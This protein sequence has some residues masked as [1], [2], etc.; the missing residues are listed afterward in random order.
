MRVTQVDHLKL[1]HVG[2]VGFEVAVRHHGRQSSQLL[3]F[4][5][6]LAAFGAEI[7]PPDRHPLVVPEVEV[8]D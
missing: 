4:R 5:P 7:G 8:E 2:H 3:V 6:C 1:D